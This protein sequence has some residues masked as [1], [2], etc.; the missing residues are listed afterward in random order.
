MIWKKKENKF[1]WSKESDKRSALYT[2]LCTLR[3]CEP[4]MDVQA[5]S[6]RIAREFSK[7][8][9]AELN[10][11][12]WSNALSLYS[13]S[14]C[15][16]ESSERMGYGFLQRGKCFFEMRMFKE[17][18]VDMDLATQYNCTN[19]EEITKRRADCLKCIDQK[20]QVVGFEPELDFREHK[21]YPGLA[22]ILKIDWN[23]QD[24][25]HIVTTA[26]IAVGK[27]VLL[28]R[29][30]AVLSCGNEQR[31]SKCFATYTN[32]VPCK[33]CTRALFCLNECEDSCEIH[34]YECG[35]QMPKIY[36]L[37]K[38]DFYPVIRS[39]I[40]AM[41]IF[42]SV[43]EL[44]DFVETIIADDQNVLPSNSIDERTKYSIFLRHFDKNYPDFSNTT[45]ANIQSIYQAL[46]GHRPLS[47]KFT[48]K[49]QQRFLMHLI[50]HH[51]SARRN[52]S[53][54]TEF[55][56]KILI[57]VIAGYFNHSCAPNS[58]ML[59]IDG[60]LVVTTCRPIKSGEQIT[61]SYHGT[62]FQ[63]PYIERQQLIEHEFF[64]KCKCERCRLEVT[65]SIKPAAFMDGPTRKLLKNSAE[66]LLYTMEKRKSVTLR[67][68]QLL[69]EHGRITWCHDLAMVLSHYFVLLHTK[70]LMKSQY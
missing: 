53:N 58:I 48:T 14:L 32:L 8:G 11:N 21:Q 52:L 37:I 10:D 13:R 46:M 41:N 6:D 44:K 68:I 7:R 12:R 9:D 66:T 4:V 65:D 39:I 59:P 26:D 3:R 63:S 62:K 42:A 45:K 34:R 23:H 2:N 16:A 70:F 15:F 40:V 1:L 56:S 27:T 29:A 35:L 47:E 67:C 20:K 69:N 31:C 24:G 49:H 60:Y 18:L 22:D 50:G 64:F 30:F 55:R 28:E 25:L 38:E 33:N 43:D 51:I 54:G 36:S 5:K 19:T 57:P 61:I 17:C